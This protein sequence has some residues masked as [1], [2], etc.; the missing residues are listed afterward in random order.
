VEKMQTKRSNV[1]AEP[2]IIFSLQYL[3]HEARCGG[4]KRL[5][6]ILEAAVSLAVGGNDNAQK[7]AEKVADEEAEAVMDFLWRYLQLDPG[8][9]EQILEAI[10]D[11]ELNSG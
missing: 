10:E 6:S 3:T 9:R 8:N 7:E 1:I 11:F 2:N 4:H 5:H